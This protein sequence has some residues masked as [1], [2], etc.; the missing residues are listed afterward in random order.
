MSRGARTESRP[1]VVVAASGST[2]I[3]TL[4]RPAKLNA[5]N[6]EMVAGLLEALEDARRA[7]AIV[8]TGAQGN[9]CAGWDLSEANQPGRDARKDPS[10]RRAVSLLAEQQCPTIAAIEGHCLGQ[11]LLYAICCD[12]RIAAATASLGF[13]EIRRGFFPG[14]S[15]S[16]RIFRLIGRALAKELMYFG[17]PITAEEAS[18][19]GLV[20]S[21]VSEGEALEEAMRWANALAKAPRTHVQATKRAIDAGRGNKPSFAIDP[22][23]E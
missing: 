9:F 13:P 4:N 17:S 19:W 11:G 2:T 14:S 16:Q 18:R 7:R 12:V 20:N 6:G 10:W 3:I 15:A 1:S 21:V 8:L 22:D 23:G 5:V